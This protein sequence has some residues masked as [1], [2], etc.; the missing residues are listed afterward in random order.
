MRELQNPEGVSYGNAGQLS[1]LL[2]LPPR[3]NSKLGAKDPA[4]K[5]DAYRNT[6]LLLAQQV[7]DRLHDWSFKTTEEREAVLLEWAL[8]EWAD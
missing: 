1:N 6:G 4:E 7:A 2:I 8:Q 3:L 5:A